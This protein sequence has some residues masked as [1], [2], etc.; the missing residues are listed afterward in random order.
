M[1]VLAKSGLIRRY[2]KVDEIAA[3][4]FRGIHARSISIQWLYS[5]QWVVLVLRSFGRNQL[6]KS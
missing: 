1:L 6:R 4:A 3:R 2:E 5:P